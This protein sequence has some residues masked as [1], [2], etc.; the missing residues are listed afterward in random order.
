MERYFIS[1]GYDSFDTR[2]VNVF[3]YFNLM[4]G[5]AWAE[6]IFPCKNFISE[7]FQIALDN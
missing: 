7:I 1:D 6:I 2:E 5:F 4:L 3:S